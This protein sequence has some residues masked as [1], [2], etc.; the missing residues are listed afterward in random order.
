MSDKTTISDNLRHLLK[1]HDDLSIS[2]LARQA[3]TAAD[4]SSFIKWGN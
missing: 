3:D 2:E 1:M 4:A